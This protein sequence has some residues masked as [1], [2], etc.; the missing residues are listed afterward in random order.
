MFLDFFGE[1]KLDELTKFHD[2]SWTFKDFNQV[3]ASPPQ[4]LALSD[5]LAHMS[6]MLGISFKIPQ[7]NSLIWLLIL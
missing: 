3:A 7:P 2:F 6:P 5:G 1:L 4:A